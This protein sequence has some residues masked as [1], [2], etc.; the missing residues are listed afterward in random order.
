[1]YKKIYFENGVAKKIIK[2]VGC[3]KVEL[4]GKEDEKEVL[5]LRKTLNVPV[6]EEKKKVEIKT[7]PKIE[8]KPIPKV[9]MPKIE[10]KKIE[11]KKT[12]EKS[13]EKPASGDKA[14]E[15]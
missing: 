14:K 9:S 13:D 7:E 6:P 3:T 2:T 5:H 12:E 15:V 11:E 8:V 10:E 4:C 1:M